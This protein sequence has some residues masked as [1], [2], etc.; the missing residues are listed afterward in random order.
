MKSLLA[1]KNAKVALLLLV[2][3]LLAFGAI[4]VWVKDNRGP[5]GT[6]VESVAPGPSGR[7]EAVKDLPR[8][9]TY[10]I[11]KWDI[12]IPYLNPFGSQDNYQSVDYTPN[13]TQEL[14]YVDEENMEMY[15]ITGGDLWQLQVQWKDSQTDPW[16]DLRLYVTQLGGK[17]YMGASEGSWVLRG[18]REPPDGESLRRAARDTC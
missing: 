2:G 15:R 10:P 18:R 12:A 8:R 5:L 13:Q 9:K 7:A 17:F 14:K 4:I 3:A 1:N 16:E 6:V 11:G